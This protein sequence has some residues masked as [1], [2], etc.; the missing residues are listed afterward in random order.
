MNEHTKS[1]IVA[2]LLEESVEIDDGH[3][4]NGYTDHSDTNHSDTGWSD[5]PSWSDSINGQHLI[6]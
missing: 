5:G 3:S 1:K 6:S 2:A 4:D